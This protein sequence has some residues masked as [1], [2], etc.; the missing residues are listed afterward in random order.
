MEENETSGPSSEFILQRI[1]RNDAQGTP[2][3]RL[4]VQMRGEFS[5]MLAEH[6]EAKNAGSRGR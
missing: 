2:G 4:N 5:R 6:V 3:W 1:I